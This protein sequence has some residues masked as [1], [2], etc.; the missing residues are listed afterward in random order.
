MMIHPVLG[1]LFAWV[2][3]M[4]LFL[5]TFE[6]SIVSLSLFLLVWMFLAYKQDAKK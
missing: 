2:S 5:H 1:A 4:N 6:S 3:T